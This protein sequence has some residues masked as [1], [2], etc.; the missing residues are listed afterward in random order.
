MLD[1]TGDWCYEGGCT[2][3]TNADNTVPTE[4]DFAELEAFYREPCEASFE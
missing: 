3:L 4:Q 2:Y 1:R